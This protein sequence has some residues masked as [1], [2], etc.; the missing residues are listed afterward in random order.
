[1]LASFLGE[2]LSDIENGSSESGNSE[3]EGDWN[4]MGDFL[5]MKNVYETHE[6]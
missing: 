5:M 2:K 1:M 3:D 4:L 6:R